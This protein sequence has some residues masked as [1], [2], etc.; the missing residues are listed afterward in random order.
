MTVSKEDLQGNIYQIGAPQIGSPSTLSGKHL[1]Y[2]TNDLL[3]E[4]EWI[5]SAA[6]T[7]MKDFRLTPKS[8]GTTLYLPYTKNFITSVRLP[9][10]GSVKLFT[11]ANMSGCKF[12]A[13]RIEDSSGDLMVYHANSSIASPK[14]APA[15][16]QSE[17]ADDDLDNMHQQAQTDYSPLTFSD[18]TSL[19]K[20]EY[21][22]QAHFMEERQAAQGRGVWSLEQKPGTTSKDVKYVK[23]WVPPAFLGGCTL[24]GFFN[25]G[26]E[27]WYQT[28]GDVE[29]EHYKNGIGI[30]KDLASRNWDSID[31][32]R[33]EGNKHEASV[34]DW[35]VVDYKRFY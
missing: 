16:F 15:N 1:S 28:W 19:A 5:P 10:D 35:S 14:H 34:K 30:I 12:F 4:D 20:P 27:F 29:Y 18:L 32:R 23:N 33:T 9:A 24:F 31:K 11:T 6:N 8:T 21:Y 26:W 25:H 2:A 3:I 7:I 17:E 22:L 13:D